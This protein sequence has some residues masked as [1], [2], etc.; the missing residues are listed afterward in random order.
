MILVEYKKQRILVCM[1]LLIHIRTLI[2]MK[3]KNSYM[4]VSPNPR[5]SI[6]M[7]QNKTPLLL[8]YFNTLRTCIDTYIIFG[9]SKYETQLKYR[10]LIYSYF[11]NF[12]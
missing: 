2:C 4:Y 12:M 9:D 8:Q 5:F 7:S 10:T 3:T 6:P 1:K 11:D